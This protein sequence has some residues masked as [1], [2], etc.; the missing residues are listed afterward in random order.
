M[1]DRILQE[2]HSQFGLLASSDMRLKMPLWTSLNLPRLI[3]AGTTVVPPVPGSKSSTQT[4]ADEL[5]ASDL[6]LGAWCPVGIFASA[7]WVVVASFSGKTV[8][9]TV[10]VPVI[11]GL[12]IYGIVIVDS[13][14]RKHQRTS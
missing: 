8:A 13:W 12:W 7:G 4:G 5:N 3:R 6:T 10:A 14:V 9:A 11:M 1:N 2:A